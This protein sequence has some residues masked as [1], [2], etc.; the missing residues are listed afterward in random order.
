MHD[1][2]VFRG[3]R[4]FT[5][6]AWQA[7]TIGAT[8]ALFALSS[9]LTDWKMQSVAW[10]IPMS[11]QQQM[12]NDRLTWTCIYIY[13]YSSTTVAMYSYRRH[14]VKTVSQHCLICKRWG[15]Q[16]CTLT[17]CN[18]YLRYWCTPVLL[19]YISRYITKDSRRH[20]CSRS[21][22]LGIKVLNQHGMCDLY[23]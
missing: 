23:W 18:G 11:S 12:C 14:H 10:W 6:Y 8:M 15:V 3:K 22:F 9:I 20:R 1:Q 19:Y 4:M 7:T 5:H 17:W 2:N 16:K 13:A 21:L